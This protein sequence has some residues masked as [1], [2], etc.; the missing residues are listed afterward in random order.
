MLVDLVGLGWLGGIIEECYLV[1]LHQWPVVRLPRGVSIQLGTG[2][3]RSHCSNPRAC[4]SPT[5]LLSPLPYPL[6]LG[7]ILARLISV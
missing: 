6:F 4:Q 3:L 1:L 7:C 2:V 5:S